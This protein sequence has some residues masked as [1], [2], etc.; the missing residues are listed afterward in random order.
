VGGGQMYAIFGTLMASAL[1][2]YILME[3]QLSKFQP[4][5]G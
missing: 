1:I 5:E 4:A 3:R 2:V